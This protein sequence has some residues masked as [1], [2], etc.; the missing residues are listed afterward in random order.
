[1]NGLLKRKMKMFNNISQLTSMMN[2]LEG[3]WQLNLLMNNFRDSEN[4]ESFRYDADAHHFYMSVIRMCAMGMVEYAKG[5]GKARLEL[6][7]C[8]TEP[9]NFR[10][11]N[12]VCIYIQLYECSSYE[13]ANIMLSVMHALTHRYINTNYY[14]NVI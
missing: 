3:I 2:C 5:H 12:S 14:R 11:S 8:C 13:H 7:C 4:R 10:R 6:I 9:S 1:M